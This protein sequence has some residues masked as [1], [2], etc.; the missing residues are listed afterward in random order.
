M[1]MLEL[2]TVGPEFTRFARGAAAAA[3]ERHLRPTSAANPPAC[4][5]TGQTDGRTDGHSTAL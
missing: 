2:F 4:R 5:S 1:S 3:I